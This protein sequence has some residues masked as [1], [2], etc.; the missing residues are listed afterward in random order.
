MTIA[1]RIVLGLSG[2]ALV[3][4]GLNTGLG[5]IQTLGLRGPT[6][7]VAPLNDIA[8]AV[9]DNNIRFLA[10]FFFAGGLVLV[11]GAWMLERLAIPIITICCMVAIGGVFRLTGEQASVALSN[12]AMPSL[13][14]EFTLFPLLAFFVYRSIR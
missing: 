9:Q 7:F 10:G 5:G 4:L 1:L 13:V 12:G 8:Y 2:L 3:A 14:L 11:A 6:D